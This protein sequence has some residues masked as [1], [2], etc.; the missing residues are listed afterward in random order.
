LRGTGNVPQVVDINEEDLKYVLNRIG[1]K[2]AVSY[3]YGL[4]LPFDYGEINLG[5][6]I[7]WKERNLNRKKVAE[8]ALLGWVVAWYSFLSKFL[9]RE[10]RVNRATYLPS[11][12]SV[13][14]KRVVILFADIRNFTTMTEMLRNAYSYRIGKENDPGPLRQIVNEYCSEMA[15]II[16][17]ENRGRID[18]FMGDGILALFG[19]YDDHPSKIVCRALHVSCQMVTKFRELKKKWQGVAFGKGYELEFNETV[20]INLG[21]GIDFGTVL[22]DYLGDEIH[23]EYSVVGDHVN[24]SQRLGGESAKQDENTKKMRP[25][26]LI[27]RTALRCCRPWLNNFTDVQISPKGKGYEYIVYGIE[28]EGFNEALFNTSE[29]NDDWESPWEKDREGSPLVA[30]SF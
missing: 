1:L 25:S 7:I 28:P 14:W 29:K 22:F 19:E 26:I 15:K 27:S 18:K 4:I 11:Y 9:C 12:Y 5:R 8:H 3:T 24:F 21:I 20:E 2:D 6:F 17:E 16:Q 30:L 10:Y 23:R 13:G